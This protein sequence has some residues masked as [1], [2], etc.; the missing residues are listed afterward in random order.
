[1]LAITFKTLLMELVS[2]LQEPEHLGIRSTIE[3]GRL[4]HFE[5]CFPPMEDYPAEYSHETAS[6]HRRMKFLAQNCANLQVFLYAGHQATTFLLDCREDYLV[7]CL[8]ETNKK[9]IR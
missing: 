7:H 4:E 1:V 9:E 6:V 3:E 5:A 2:T 8:K